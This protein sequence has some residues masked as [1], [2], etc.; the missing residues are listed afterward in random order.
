MTT[1]GSI[2]LE[3]GFKSATTNNIVVLVY[4]TFQSGLKFN[5]LQQVIKSDA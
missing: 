3:L 5:N 4:M 1:K 2:S